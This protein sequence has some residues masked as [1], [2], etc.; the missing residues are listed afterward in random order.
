[1]ADGSRITRAEALERRRREI[2][3]GALADAALMEAV[4]EGIAAVERGDPRIP[5]RVLR[6]ELQRRH[7]DTNA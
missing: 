2:V 3:E 1:M 5:F 4:R 6:E 7:L